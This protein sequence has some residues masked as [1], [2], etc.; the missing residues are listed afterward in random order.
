MLKPNKSNY[1]II[2]SLLPKNNFL[3]EILSSWKSAFGDKVFA[4]K[5]LLLPG[6]FFLY[7][8][9]TQKIGIYIEQRK[10]IQV[11]DT[12]LNYIPQF[13]FSVPIFVLLYTSLFLAIVTHLNQPKIIYRII[14]MHLLVAVIRQICIFL[15][16]LDPPN[17]IIVLRDIFLENTV[18]PRFS[19]L[20]KD[21][22]FSGHV[23]SIWLYFLCV[24]HKL[25]KKYLIV[26]TFFM[27]FMILSMRVH[28]T[29]DVYGAIII[30]SIIYF[31]PAWFRSFYL[32]KEI[33]PDSSN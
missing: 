19:P 15:V 5:I 9:I 28:Y 1:K 4:I 26:A 33:L 21:L 6:F 7:S 20:T 12:L 25:V 27:A 22:F 8:A 14:E 31:A 23:A 17:G 11:N 16:A 10:G 32:S 3:Q 29:F 18:Y 2:N 24:Q 13:D 30:T